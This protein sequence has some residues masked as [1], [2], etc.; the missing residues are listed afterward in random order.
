MWTRHTSSSA[1]TAAAIPA[2]LCLTRAS[3]TQTLL[4]ML[5]TA[6]Q[7]SCG[8][9]HS[10]RIC[11]RQTLHMSFDYLSGS[12][13][14]EV[15]W[16]HLQLLALS[17]QQLRL[18]ALAHMVLL[19]L[20]RQALAAQQGWNPAHFHHRAASSDVRTTTRIRREV[21]DVFLNCLS[22]CMLLVDEV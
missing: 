3:T 11:R 13:S 19:N 12:G 9:M 4:L 22:S 8:R 6:S 2:D 1:M 17:M 20:G 18:F 14:L 10:G 16:H 7:L 21:Q 5:R 15:S